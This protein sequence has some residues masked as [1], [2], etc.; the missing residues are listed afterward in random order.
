M[1][2]RFNVLITEPAFADL[3][4]ILAYHTSVLAA[5]QA[6]TKL[7]DSFEKI[8]D[9]LEQLPTAYPKVRNTK[10]ASFGY[11]WAPLAKSYAV[12]YRIDGSETVTIDRILYQ[13]RQWQ[14]VLDPNKNI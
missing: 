1:D 11:H 5:P 8:K 14:T 4:E 12:F 13:A 7:L 6:A 9:E 2:A 10:L 3:D